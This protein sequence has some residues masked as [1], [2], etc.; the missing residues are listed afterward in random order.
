LAPVFLTFFILMDLTIAWLTVYLY[1]EGLAQE[2][3]IAYGM[4][5]LAIIS[6]VLLIKLI[7]AVSSFHNSDRV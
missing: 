1:R 3:T 5:G 6:F 4:C 7:P 2:L